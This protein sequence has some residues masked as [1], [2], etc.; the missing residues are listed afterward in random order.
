MFQPG[1]LP[2]PMRVI[3][4]KLPPTVT[5]EAFTS[6]DCV[7]SLIDGGLATVQ[8]LSAE[9]VGPT[10]APPSAAAVVTIFPPV[11]DGMMVIRFTQQI[12]QQRFEHP[13]R[14]GT[15]LPEVEWAPLQRLPAPPTP[16]PSKPPPSI[17]EDPEFMAFAKDY[18]T[19][20]V[21]LTDQLLSSEEIDQSPDVID[22]GRVIDYLNEKLGM[23]DVRGKRVKKGSA[24]RGSRTG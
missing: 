23:R 13:M 4:R 9:F 6:L 5:E 20:Y 17:D 14:P 15:V 24:R 10:A 16:S 3:C 2:V 19:N 18:E 22:G 8:F 12:S 7:R 11:T 21:P 1:L